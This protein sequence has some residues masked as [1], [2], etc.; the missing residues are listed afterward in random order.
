MFCVKCEYFNDCC[1]VFMMVIILDIRDNYIIP[2]LW[3][4]R[5]LYCRWCF[6][7]KIGFIDHLYTQL[8]TKSNYS[9]ITNLHNLQI[10]TAHTKC[11]P[12]CCVFTSCSL[13]VAS[14]S[15][16]SSASALKSCLN[17]GSLPTVLFLHSPW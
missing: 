6:G 13:I 7:F 14:N 1:V 4:V 9:T 11:F 2:E 12:A 3:S 17:G 8:G 15:R 5:N 16:D 10:A